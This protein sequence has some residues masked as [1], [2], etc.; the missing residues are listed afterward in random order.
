MSF[1]SAA[2]WQTPTN[3]QCGMRSGN[4]ADGVVAKVRYGDE[5]AA[6]RVAVGNVGR[7]GNLLTLATLQPPGGAQFVVRYPAGYSFFSA[8]AAAG[9]GVVVASGATVAGAARRVVGGACA[10]AAGDGAGVV[11]ATGTSCQWP[12]STDHTFPGGTGP[13]G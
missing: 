2:C 3:L 10:V 12:C 9:A 5:R 6:R 4:N 1:R 8:G 11:S 7:K 13:G